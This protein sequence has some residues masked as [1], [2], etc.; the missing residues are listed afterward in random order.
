MCIRDSSKLVYL[1]EARPAETGMLRVGQPVTV[2]VKLREMSK[3][4]SKGNSK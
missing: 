1:V 2:E 3:D 4:T